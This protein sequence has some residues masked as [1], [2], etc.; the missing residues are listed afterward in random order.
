[1]PRQTNERPGK[2]R[3][4]I[5][6]P[7]GRFERFRIER[8]AEEADV[9]DRLDPEW[10]PP[11][12]RTTLTPEVTRTII[13]RNDSPDIPFDRS[14]NP[15]KGC[16]H[17]CVYCFARPTHAYLGLSPGLDFETRIFTKPDAAKLLR[18]E[19]GRPGYKCAVMAL[20][21]N[22]DPYQPAEREL[23]ITRAIL[24]VL[25][26]HDH[27][28]GIVT[29]STLVLRD[30]DILR[31][32]AKKSLASVMI[33]ITTLEGDLARRMEPRAAAP[34]RR[35]ETVRAIAEA[36]VPA[37]VL[38]SPMIPGLNDTE[39]ERILEACA[40][41]GATSAGYTLLRLPLEIKDLF[42]EWLQEHYPS[43]AS[44]VLSLVRDTRGGRL[45]DPSFGSRM[46]GT[47]AYAGLIRRRFEVACRRLGLNRSSVALDTTRFRA[48]R[49]PSDQHGLRF[50]A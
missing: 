31:E 5:S 12:V 19:L 1:M 36:R 23:R 21:S 22:T 2:R 9:W 26:E 45:N 7:T 27:P 38:A 17:G 28:V 24:E 29:K 10:E 11:P 15:Y 32:M 50:D 47:G 44:H 25:A 42:A 13:T 8:I 30:L 49:P 37:G 46:R 16:E 14:I 43:R 20:G 33:S 40:R 35:L 41:S 39:L 3:G 48:P 6:N 34:G 18:A 4:A